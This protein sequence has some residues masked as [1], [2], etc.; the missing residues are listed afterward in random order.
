MPTKKEF[1]VHLIACAT[2]IE[3]MLPLISNTMS[4]EKLD[5]GLHKNPEALKKK[6]QNRL[7]NLPREIH[8]VILGYGLCSQAVVGL[9]GGR[10]TLIL[11]RVDDCIAIFLGS[12]G[13]RREQNRINPGT[14][15]LTKGWIEA[16]DS[17]FDEFE[18]FEKKYGPDA[19]RRI[20]NRMLANYSRLAFINTGPQDLERYRKRAQETAA[21]FRLNFEE[22]I[23]SDS[24]IRK[25]INNNWDDEFVLVKPGGT[26]LLQNFIPALTVS[27]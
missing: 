3:E 20:M 2:V 14:Y 7:E 22:I 13:A 16:G 27:A 23:G 18:S 24:L 26:V 19:A 10:C 15:Y 12:A 25:M 1:G 5:F 6:L 9:T 11:P 8:T 17:P 4:Y 21:K